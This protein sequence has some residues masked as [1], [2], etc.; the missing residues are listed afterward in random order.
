MKETKTETAENPPDLSKQLAE[1]QAELAEAREQIRAFGIVPKEIE[2]LVA[3][4]M[5]M[6]LN[7]E[8]AIECAR[9]Q[10]AHNTVLAD[11]EKIV[12]QHDDPQEAA[13]LTR[14]KRNAAI[15]K[16]LIEAGSL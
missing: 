10:I 13:K 12:V 4:K 15:G 5:R 1:S 14:Q 2:P 16:K 9:R 7:K 6:G 3:Q 11:A 8:Q